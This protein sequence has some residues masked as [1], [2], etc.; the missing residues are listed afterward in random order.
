M[1]K[2]Q[3]RF[4][5]DDESDFGVGPKS[6]G[7]PLLFPVLHWKLTPTRGLLDRSDWIK[8]RRYS[9]IFFKTLLMILKYKNHTPILVIYWRA[10][11]IMITLQMGD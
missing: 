1:E 6:Y 3:Q 8:G 4:Y 2:T 7:N 9:K 10:I 11:E 5:W